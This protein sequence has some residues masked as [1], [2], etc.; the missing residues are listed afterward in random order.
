[1]QYMRVALE[2]LSVWAVYFLFYFKDYIL[3]YVEKQKHCNSQMNNVSKYPS[4][5]S[6]HLAWKSIL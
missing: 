1:M 5:R 3:P 6:R 4:W 2:Q